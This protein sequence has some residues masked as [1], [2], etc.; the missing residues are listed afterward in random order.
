[1]AA[2]NC[3]KEEKYSGRKINEKTPVNRAKFR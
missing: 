2:E 3:S 1:M